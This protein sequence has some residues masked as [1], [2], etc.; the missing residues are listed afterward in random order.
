MLLWSVNGHVCIPVCREQKNILKTQKKRKS[1]T[2]PP[3]WLLWESHSLHWPRY[4]LGERVFLGGEIVNLDLFSSYLCCTAIALLLVYNDNLALN[5]FCLLH[6][7]ILVVT[8][9]YSSAE[10]WFLCVN[11]KMCFMLTALQLCSFGLQI[12]S[13]YKSLLQII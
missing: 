9:W 4:I 1:W 8:K 2:K 5:T 10:T 12:R 13:L 6:T 3:S 7:Q 11:E